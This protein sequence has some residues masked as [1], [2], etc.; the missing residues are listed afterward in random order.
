M[1]SPNILTRRSFLRR[2]AVL[3]SAGACAGTIRDFR[4][5]NSL[6]AAQNPNPSGP[7]KALVCVF[8]GGGNDS[9]NWI[10]PTDN[11]TYGEYA[12]ARGNLVLP[13][14]SLLPL[15]TGPLGSDSAYSYQGRTYGFHPSCSRLQ[16]LFG[17]KKLAIVQN[18]GTL[19]RPTTKAQYNSGLVAYR[20]PQLFSHSDQVTQWQTSIPDVPPTTGWGG[21]VADIYNSVANPTGKI[22]MNV[23]IAGANTFEIGNLVSQYHAAT[24]GA[25]TLSGGAMMSG[26]GARVRAMKD[27]M[28]LSNSN[29]QRQAY[30]SVLDSAIKVGDLLNGN[31]TAKADPTDS[32]LGG[33]T[34]AQQVTGFNGGQTFKWSTGLTGI[35]NPAL[36]GFTDGLG[37]FPNTSLGTQLK[38]V[39]RLIAA[40]GPTGFDMK[41][42][43]F[44]VTAGG[45]DT[46]TAQVDGPGFTNQPTNTAGTHYGL[47]Q[48]VSE[49]MFAFQRAMEQ[50]DGGAPAKPYSTGVTAFTASD[51]ARTFPSNSQGSDHGWGSHHIIVGGA[52]DGGKM[53]GKLPAFAINGPDDTGTGRWLPTLSV[54][55]HTAT[56]AQWYGLDSNEVTGLLPNLSRFNT[57][58]ANK[59]I[60]FMKPA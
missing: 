29:L 50:L 4:L 5:M 49:A 3:G 19:V 26:A 34:N 40:N 18:V 41:R 59:F 51:F 43:I 15:R 47:L 20:P 28:A 1:N 8:L 2:A 27:I 10:V 23:S 17:E 31:I 32:P 58:F 14:S 21:R 54:D 33:Y 60:G 39:A 36:T 42:Q 44:Y 52:V 9:N 55:E 12:A 46:H 24:T 13:Q 37:G 30:A 35:Y 7:Y 57:S 56:L 48:Q 25:V 6:M 11:T 38:M 16:T 53:F 45:W 22:S